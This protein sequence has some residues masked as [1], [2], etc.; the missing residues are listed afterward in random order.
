[1]ARKI[2]FNKVINNLLLE[3]KDFLIK[4]IQLRDHM[5][6]SFDKFKGILQHDLFERTLKNPDDL[7]RV[8]KVAKPS[9]QI[10]VFDSKNNEFKEE[11][12]PAFTANDN[13][14]KIVRD[15]FDY[16]LH[17]FSK[18]FFAYHGIFSELFN[19]IMKLILKKTKLSSLTAV[20]DTYYK[21]LMNLTSQDREIIE[22]K[23][24]KLNFKI[25]LDVALKYFKFVP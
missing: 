24:E 15:R 23:Y 10:F 20:Y 7:L 5:L 16:I 17:V 14:D 2:F 11:Y 6:S 19:I 18:N 4:N 13:E 3:N 9:I 8:L 1:M 12:F 22:K 25:E 21:R